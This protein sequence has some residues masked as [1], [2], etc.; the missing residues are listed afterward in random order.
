MRKIWLILVFSLLICVNVYADVSFKD[1]SSNDKINSVV[2][3]G[4]NIYCGYGSGIYKY[5]MNGNNET[6]IYSDDGTEYQLFFAYSGKLYFAEGYGLDSFFERANTKILDLSTG[7]VVTVFD[8]YALQMYLGEDKVYLSSYI[9]G[10]FYPTKFYCC[11]LDGSNFHQ[12]SDRWA[13]SHTIKDG[14]LYYLEFLNN[15][16]TNGGF[17]IIKSDYNGNNKTTTQFIASSDGSHPGKLLDD[18]TVCI[19]NGKIYFIEFDYDNKN[20]EIYDSSRK[21]IYTLKADDVRNYSVNNGMFYGFSYTYNKGSVFTLLAYRIANETTQT[22]TNNIK[23]LLNG[24]PISFP[25]SPTII[26]GTTMVP[27]R[28]V[29]EALGAQVNWNGTTRCV[30]ATKDGK[31]IT[32]CIGEKSVQID[33]VTYNVSVAPYISGQSTMIPLRFVSEALGA[34][35]NW[36]GQTKTVTIDKR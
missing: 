35:V 14:A 22:N 19:D 12:I 36:N 29:F 18:Y 7:N 9:R 13:Y 31:T 15:N 30:D 17:N 27:M 28:A 32:L 1:K 26:D 20:I 21:N 2:T 8:D 34:D 10:D 33:G 25:E 23:I 24:T 16:S 3:D 11:E 5:D 4:N 6:K